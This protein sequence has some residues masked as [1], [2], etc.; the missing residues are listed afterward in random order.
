MSVHVG[1]VCLSTY[2]C[3]HIYFI[4]IYIYICVYIYTYVYIY[5]YIYICKHTDSAYSAEEEMLQL[6]SLRICSGH[7]RPPLLS[8]SSAHP[9][10]PSEAH[11][12]GGF[13]RLSTF[14]GQQ[15][16]AKKLCEYRYKKQI[17]LM[18]ECKPS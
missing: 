17:N 2:A 3:I 13:L 1:Y 18:R 7:A 14:G 5:I 12:R 16:L 8:F 9:C 10:K 15:R 6:P 4:Y 11:D